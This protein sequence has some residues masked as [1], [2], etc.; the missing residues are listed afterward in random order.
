MSRTF[1][2]DIGRPPVP[3]VASQAEQ[4]YAMK[5]QEMG[6]AKLKGAFWIEKALYHVRNSPKLSNAIF[7]FYLR[8]Q[9]RIGNDLGFRRRAVPSWIRHLPLLEFGFDLLVRLGNHLPRNQIVLNL[10]IPIRETAALS[11]PLLS[12]EYPMPRFLNQ[13]PKSIHVRTPND[14]NLSP[15]PL[16]VQDFDMRYPSL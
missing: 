13:L 10:C 6:W 15:T 5:V 9:N 3:S 8:L 1:D 7:A 11:L 4:P 16:E 2:S 12:R 14:S